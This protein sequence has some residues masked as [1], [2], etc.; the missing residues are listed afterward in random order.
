M[1]SGDITQN[2]ISQLKQT[3][4]Q[5][6]VSNLIQIADQWGMNNTLESANVE[7]TETDSVFE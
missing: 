1:V 2:M 3:A 6:G 7:E 5:E 4:D